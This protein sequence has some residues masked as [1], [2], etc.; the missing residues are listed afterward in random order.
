M[1]PKLIVCCGSA[2]IPWEDLVLLYIVVDAKCAATVQAGTIPR[3][4]YNHWRTWHRFMELDTIR[5]T[6]GA[7]GRSL[8]LSWSREYRAADSRDKVYSLLGLLN[9]EDRTRYGINPNYD[10]RN[11]K[12]DVYIC[13]AKACLLGPERSTFLE[14]TSGTESMQGLPSWV[15]NWTERLH[16]WLEN[17]GS[18]AG[19]GLPTSAPQF[20]E[21][22]IVMKITC[23][24]VGE[25]KERSRIRGDITGLLYA[26]GSPEPTLEVA[27][28]RIDPETA[29]DKFLRA[30]C[31]ENKK[32]PAATI[33]Q[34]WVHFRLTDGCVGFGTSRAE[35][36]DMVAVL[37]G[38][39]SPY[40]FRKSV[41]R[42]GYHRLIGQCW[43]SDVME[44][45]LSCWRRMRSS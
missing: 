30:L 18:D 19:L 36:Q 43:V 8:L 2:S 34:D 10:Q 38:C 33:M 13:A 7:M 39:N 29:Y 41:D 20:L 15:P 22:D 3:K 21:S 17:K 6:P 4:L 1:S 45:P 26:K 25:I 16:L 27:R 37:P 11:C 5:R 28:L 24:M 31:L 42:P 32:A 35:V 23:V 40:I 9:E 14:E 44:R 12:Q